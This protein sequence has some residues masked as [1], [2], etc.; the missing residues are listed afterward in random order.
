VQVEF[1]NNDSESHRLLTDP[2]PEH[3]VCPEMM[4]LGAMGPQRSV[5]VTFSSDRRHGN[6]G[7][8]VCRYHDETRSD[9]R[10]FWGSIVV[11]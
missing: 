4:D 8:P 7:P 2:H 11:R 10:R 5:F 1:F 3:N 9:D 6:L